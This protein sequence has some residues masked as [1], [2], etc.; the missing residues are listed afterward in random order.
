M[1]FAG[2]GII[3]S[4]QSPRYL[5]LAS[6]LRRS[7]PCSPLL[8][9]CSFA[10]FQYIIQT[11]LLWSKLP[12]GMGKCRDG[13]LIRSISI[14]ATTLKRLMVSQPRTLLRLSLYR[15]MAAHKK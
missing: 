6:A 9:R 3:P 10:S 2:C 15:L 14:F 12:A 7:Q 4:S 11:I 13:F 1:R 5:H 8:I